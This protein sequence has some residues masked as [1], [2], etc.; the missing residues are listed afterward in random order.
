MTTNRMFES[1]PPSNAEGLWMCK[2]EGASLVYSGVDDGEGDNSRFLVRP[3]EASNR[4]IVE[5]DNFEC[6][7]SASVE[8]TVEAAL[9]LSE[10]LKIAAEIILARPAESC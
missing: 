10:A 3:R 2:I 9:A 4:I 1:T 6:D 8:M 7:D 5:V